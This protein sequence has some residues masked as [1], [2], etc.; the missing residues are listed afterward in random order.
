MAR[1]ELREVAAEAGIIGIVRA[2]VGAW[3]TPTS[4]YG[5][6]QA[7]G[8][9]P[10]DALGR[11]LGDRL[12]ESGG[13]GGLDMLGSGR[14]GGGDGKGTVGTG[15]LSTVGRVG[16]GDDGLGYG[17]NASGGLG[18]R[19]PKVPKIRV[20]HAD[21][22]GS[23]SKEVIRRVIH[24]HLN[25][26]RHCYE[27]ALVGRPDLAGRVAVKFIIAPTGAVQMTFVA[28]SDLGNHAVDACIA[29]AVGR[30][31]FP[32]PEGGGV[33][34]VNYPFVLQQVGN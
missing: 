16:Q 18:P 4:P 5:R 14:G 21:V 22:R 11:L 26:V 19:V 25:E 10:M 23:L 7:I 27:Q 30:W 20:G 6:E 8:S 24:A 1:E 2:N 12:G 15:D 9:D 31:T 17:R 28:Q 34:V 33:V 32:A 13:R 29:G 3:N